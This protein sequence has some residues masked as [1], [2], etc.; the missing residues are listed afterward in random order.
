MFNNFVS[1][2]TVALAAVSPRRVDDDR[3]RVSARCLARSLAPPRS[4]R[5][6]TCVSGPIRALADGARHHFILIMIFAPEG[7]IARLRATLTRKGALI[8]CFYERIS[9]WTAGILEKHNGRINR[10][11]RG[12][13][14]MAQCQRRQPDQDRSARAA[15]GVVAVG[16]Q[17]E[18]EGVQ[19]YLDQVKA[20]WVAARSNCDRGRRLQPRHRFGRNARRLVE[21]GNC[22]MLIGNLLATPDW[23]LPLRQGHRLRHTS[24][25]SL[26][27]TT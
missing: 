9:K 26:L 6:R 14:T 8:E 7:I 3:R 13:R 25:R 20:R 5:W 21:Q 2:S 17:G 24:F 10:R 22:H 1:P 18:V 16:R 4:S 12:R 19:F 27:L 15:P 11:R 23:R